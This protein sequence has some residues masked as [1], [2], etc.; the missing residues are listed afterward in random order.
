M[1]GTTL[2]LIFAAAL[3]REASGAITSGDNEAILMQLCHALQLAD[4]PIKFEPAL[5]DGPSE[6]K[7]LYRLNMSLAPHNWRSK[8][9]KTDATNKVI[10]APPP[11][12]VRDAEWKAKWPV[13]TE[14]AVHISEKANVEE[15]KK[16]YHILTA[17]EDQLQQ[18]REAVAYYAEA[19]YE[20]YSTYKAG[21]KKTPAT[22]VQLAKAIT[23][24]VY[25]KD[26][27]TYETTDAAALHSGPAAAYSMVCT[28]AGQQKAGNTVAGTIL[29]VC[30]VDS[31]KGTTDPCHRESNKEPKWQAGNIPQAAQWQVIRASCGIQP[32][33]PITANRIA[34]A[35]ASALAT[36]RGKNTDVYIGKHASDTCDGNSNAACLKITGAADS[37]VPKTDALP[38]AQSLYNVAKQ[39]TQREATN[40]KRTSTNLSIQ[41]LELLA[42]EASR[43]PQFLT[44]PLTAGTT[45]EKNRTPAAKEQKEDCTQHKINA[46]CTADNNCKWTNTEK[47]EGNF[48]KPKPGSENTAAGTGNGAAETTTEKFKGKLEDSCK[49]DTG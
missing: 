25:G 12:E 13:W 21:E 22:D 34:A 9:S 2:G 41:Q 17:T 28:G 37:G 40:G 5:A 39:L 1:Q 29:C 27:A 33:I 7:D 43:R 6:P 18:L 32:H 15:I 19:A 45:G 11:L 44:A 47:T 20:V 36:L 24:A 3:T 8:F 42:K 49:K 26:K 31:G 10:A 23:D 38:W 16:K 30:G 35:A 48:C 14:A 4:A 46:S